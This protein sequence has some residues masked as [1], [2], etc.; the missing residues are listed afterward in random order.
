MKAVSG[1][2]RITI[3]Q[4][5][6]ATGLSKIRVKYNLRKLKKEGVLRRVGPDRGGYWEVKK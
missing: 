6:K 3:A 5:S 1:N 4:L 2:P